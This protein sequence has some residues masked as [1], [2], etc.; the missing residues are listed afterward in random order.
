MSDKNITQISNRFD[1]EWQ[2]AKKCW[3]ILV[4][5]EGY[6]EV[7]EFSTWNVNIMTGDKRLVKREFITPQK[8]SYRGKTLFG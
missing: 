1:V 4:K 6:P 5:G 3:D 7:P 8:V 2:F